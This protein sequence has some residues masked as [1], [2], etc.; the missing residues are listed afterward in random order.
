MLPDALLGVLELVPLLEPVSEVPAA[1]EL[2]VDCVLVPDAL[3]AADG[4]LEPDDADE[5][6]VLPEPLVT[7]A[8]PAACVS[9]C[10]L[11]WAFARFCAALASSS[12]AFF[13]SPT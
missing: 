4:P 10:L 12:H 11:A 6:G 7:F 9:D 1:G 13:A 5:P 2:G 8:A 3:P